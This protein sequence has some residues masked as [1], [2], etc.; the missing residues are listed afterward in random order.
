M[1]AP[2]SALAIV[3]VGFAAL[4]SALSAGGDAVASTTGSDV[5]N[6]RCAACH[7]MEKGGANKLGPNLYCVR[8]RLAG[9]RPGFGY[10]NAMKDSGLR[11]TNAKLDAFLANPRKA[12][13]G[14]KMA[15]SGISMASD[16]A[17][18]VALM[19]C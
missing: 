3:S 8:G 4:L 19:G 17:Q 5:F 14:N 2:Y 16:R 13:P 6:R 15:F 9:T 11:W 1:K 12:L 7:T 18:V 10:S